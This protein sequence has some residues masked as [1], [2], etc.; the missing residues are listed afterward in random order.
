MIW[1]RKLYRYIRCG[2][3]DPTHQELIVTPGGWNIICIAMGR[4]WESCKREKRIKCVVLVIN[5]IQQST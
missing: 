2:R 4:D 5:D 3:Y 1:S